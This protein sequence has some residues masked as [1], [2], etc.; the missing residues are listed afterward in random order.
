MLLGR[1][2]GHDTTVLEVLDVMKKAVGWLVEVKANLLTM[3]ASTSLQPPVEM[4]SV[5]LLPLRE[6]LAAAPARDG[7]ARAPVALTKD[8]LIDT[9]ADLALRPR[10][11]AG[12]RFWTPSWTVDGAVM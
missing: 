5:P 11:T 4:I 6:L 10:A 12:R 2:L 9:L 1:G 7:E 3:S 8:W